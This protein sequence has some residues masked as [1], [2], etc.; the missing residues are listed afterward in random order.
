MLH[1]DNSW[2]LFLDRDGVINIEKEKDYINSL[3]EFMVYP[4][5]YEAIA[6]L[7][8][9]FKYV[10]VV[11]NQKGVGKGVTPEEEVKKIHGQLMES[12]VQ[13]GGRVDA[14]YYCPD[15]ADESPCRKPNP[16]MAYQASKDFKGIDLE[17][18]LMVGNNIS[19]LR[20]GR[21]AGMKTAFVRTT[22]P[23]QILPEGLCDFEAADF[24]ALAK[25]LEKHFGD[26]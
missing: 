9:L 3:G 17:K 16:G 8:Q 23:H 21:N 13:A 25:L 4:G 20:F 18:S 7:S 12:V 22:S 2:S 19:D 11:T 10:I 6:R 14:I 15:L 1:L 5:V 26:C 24:P